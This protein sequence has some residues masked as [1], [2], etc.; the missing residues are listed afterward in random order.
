MALTVFCPF[1]EKHGPCTRQVE[2]SARLMCWYYQEMMRE[3]KL[4]RWN[5][6]T[7]RMEPY[8]ATDD[9]GMSKT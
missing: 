9:Q 4:M 1:A 3:A 2:C 6:N 8:S 5:P 7:S